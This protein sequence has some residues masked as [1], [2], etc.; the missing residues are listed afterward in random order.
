MKKTLFLRVEV[1]AHPDTDPMQ[2]LSDAA[3]WASLGLG[4]NAIKVDVTAF[5]SP[6]DAVADMAA[7]RAPAGAETPGRYMV[8]LFALVDATSSEHANDMMAAVQQC[9]LQKDVA[10]YQ[11]EQLP[12]MLVPGEE[13]M[14][15]H[16]IIDYCALG[17][18]QQEETVR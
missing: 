18:C 2:S 6:L 16:S 15:A 5:N 14:E 10:L 17:E 1:D 8:P 9:A 12:T 13:S 11:D 7:L 4:S 3:T